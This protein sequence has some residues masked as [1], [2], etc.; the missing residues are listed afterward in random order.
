M[1][2]TNRGG[3]IYHGFGSV[4]N[5]A[6]KHLI[7]DHYLSRKPPMQDTF[8]W[9]KASR[10]LAIMTLGTP[11]SREAQK[12]ACPDDPNLVVELNRLWIADDQPHG[13]A[14]WFIAQCLSDM[15]PRIVLSY[16]D[17]AVGHDG[18][19]YRAAN[20]H[21]AGWT[22]MDRKTPRFDYEIS[23]TIV[24]LFGERQITKHGRDA[25]R[26]GKQFN[27]V[28]RKPKARYWTVTGTKKDKKRLR[29][30]CKWPIMCWKSNPV[31]TSHKQAP[32]RD[33]IGECLP[34]EHRRE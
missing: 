30:L 9:R 34:Q 21:Y 8:E 22:D 16:A 33:I 14:S 25:F 11:A 4:T 6:M 7:A 12:G 26:S 27:R 3:V 31:P 28:R 24:D 10:V 17:T 32:K 29:A 23:E 18:T 5:Q 15:P 20:F 2:N 19:V 13:T 1:T